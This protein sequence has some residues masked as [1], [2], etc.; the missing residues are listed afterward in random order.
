MVPPVGE[1]RN[2]YDIFA[3]IAQRMDVEDAFT[4]GRDMVSWQEWMY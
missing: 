2:D 3:N 4:E 1:A